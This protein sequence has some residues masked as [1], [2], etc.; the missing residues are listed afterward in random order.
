MTKEVEG[1]VYHFVLSEDPS[2][3][4]VPMSIANV[5]AFSLE[6]AAER[7]NTRL[8]GRYAKYIGHTPVSLFNATFGGDEEPTVP[9]PPP[10]HAPEF[11]IERDRSTVQ[12]D[13]LA[14]YLRDKGYNVE[15]PYGEESHDEGQA[16]E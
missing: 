6:E 8:L 12:L 16:P 9:D 3:H 13:R 15:T 10:E 1:K 5:T 7:L 11:D 14:Q 2:I 4:L